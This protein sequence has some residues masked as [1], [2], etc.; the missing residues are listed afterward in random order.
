[1]QRREPAEAADAVNKG[2]D[3]VVGKLESKKASG[4]GSTDVIE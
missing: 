3:R 4:F 2:I 1:M